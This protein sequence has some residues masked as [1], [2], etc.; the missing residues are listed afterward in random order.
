MAI[1]QTKSD[2]GQNTDEGT[3]P[4]V[5]SLSRREVAQIVAICIGKHNPK[6]IFSNGLSVS[7]KLVK[8]YE[9]KI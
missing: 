7:R 9:R 6:T 8:H 5:R 2:F 1:F 4:S 3:T